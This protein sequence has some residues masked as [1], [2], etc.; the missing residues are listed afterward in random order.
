M[1]NTRHE[2]NHCVNEE[3]SSVDLHDKTTASLHTLK[4]VC[5]ALQFK[6]VTTSRVK[7][8]PVLPDTFSRTQITQSVFIS[9]NFCRSVPSLI[10]VVLLKCSFAV[11][12][13]Y[14]LYFT[15][16]GSHFLMSKFDCIP[17]NSSFN[18]LS[19]EQFQVSL[20]TTIIRNVLTYRGSKESLL[21]CSMSW[22]TCDSVVFSSV[23]F[24]SWDLSSLTAWRRLSGLKFSCSSRCF[25][26]SWK[27][28]WLCWLCWYYSV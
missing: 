17:W 25:T 18:Y 3:I 26:A 20:P 12:S 19:N 28:S 4:D 8:K 6:V 21:L 2:T 14:F 1:P 10:F 7:V 27:R 13:D 24:K 16:F 15:Q 9:C 5:R 23:M 22:F 11:S